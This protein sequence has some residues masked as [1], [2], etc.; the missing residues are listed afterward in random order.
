[1]CNRIQE[2]GARRFKQY[3]EVFNYKFSIEPEF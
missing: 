2:S 3:F 1:M